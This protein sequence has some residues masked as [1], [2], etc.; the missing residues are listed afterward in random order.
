MGNAFDQNRATPVSIQ[1]FP[2]RAWNQSV[3]TYNQAQAV[4]LM[5]NVFAYMFTN[6]GDTAAFVN[7]MLI[8]PGVPGTSLGDSRTMA[9]HWMDLYKG[10]LN[11][12]FQIPVGV[13]PLVEIVQFFYVL[14]YN[15]KQH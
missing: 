10:T 13:A 4:P 11:L 5:E 3:S 1:D 12:A 9:G 2:F 7:G 6:L 14:P 8:L 15:K